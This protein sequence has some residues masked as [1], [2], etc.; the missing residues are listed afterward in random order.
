MNTKKRTLTKKE[1][2]E[3][4]TRRGFEVVNKRE[5]EASGSEPSKRQRVSSIEEAK[6]IVAELRQFISTGMKLINEALDI[7]DQLE[8]KIN[9]TV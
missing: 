1:I 5:N 2:Q 4:L 9:K 8:I 7:T 3:E 6:T